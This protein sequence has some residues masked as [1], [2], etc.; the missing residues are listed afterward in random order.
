MRLVFDVFEFLEFF[1]ELCQHLGLLGVFSDI[2]IDDG[3]AKNS[4]L[5]FFLVDYFPGL[6]QALFLL[7]VPNFIL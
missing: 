4:K 7:E 2:V 1:F 5:T 6:L 3:I